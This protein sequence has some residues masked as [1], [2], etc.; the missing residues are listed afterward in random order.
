MKDKEPLR[1][2]L[3]WGGKNESIKPI[4]YMTFH[5]VL[6]SLTFVVLGPLLWH[7]F[8]LHTLYLLVLLSMAIKNSASYYFEVF[9]ER[10]SKTNDGVP[11]A[12]TD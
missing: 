8:V 5:G 12:A 10:Y 4:I 11:T 7:S 6:C 1:G 9:A 2:I 3:S